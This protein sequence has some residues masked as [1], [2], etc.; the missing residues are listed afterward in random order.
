MTTPESADAS[1]TAGA[2]DA[3]GAATPAGRPMTPDAALARH[4]EWLEYALGVARAEEADRTRRLA[5]AT[6]KNHDKRTARLSEV[7]DEIAELTALLQGIRDLRTG[8]EP[9]SKRRT[10]TQA[11]SAR[12]KVADRKSK[13]PSSGSTAAGSPAKGSGA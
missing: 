11:R 6:K 4:V 1:R 10:T 2:A 5:K 13:V 9:A 12:A 3:A 8:A 7:R